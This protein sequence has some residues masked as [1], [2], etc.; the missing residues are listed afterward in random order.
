MSLG[1]RQNVL[2]A[3]TGFKF[4]LSGL[5]LEDLVRG[6]T[7]GS[8]AGAAARTEAHEEDYFAAAADHSSVPKRKSST[9]LGQKNLQKPTAQLRTDFDFFP[10]SSASPSSSSVRGTSLPTAAL[11]RGQHAQYNY[12]YLLAAAFPPLSLPRGSEDGDLGRGF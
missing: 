8:S 3:E 4:R 10:R 11:P 5:K 2:E 12:W 1:L 9:T 6:D 7:A